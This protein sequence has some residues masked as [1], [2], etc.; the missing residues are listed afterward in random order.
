MRISTFILFLF[1]ALDSAAQITHP[2]A[3]PFSVMEQEVGLSKITIQYSRPAVKGRTVF[4]QLVPYSRIWRV[5][6]NASTKITLDSDIKVLGNTLS[7]G[8]YALYAFPNENTWE[9]V[10]HNTTTH[11]G[12][13]R[14]AYDPAEDALRVT[15]IPE[16]IPYSQENFLITFDNITHNSLDMI[17]IWENAKIVVPMTVDTHNAML[18]EIAKQLHQNPTA[19][20]YYE[21]ARY[22]QEQGMEYPLALEYLNKAI[23]LGGDTYYFHRV[24][25]LVEAAL[26]DYKAALV[27][28]QK[29]MVIAAKEGKDEFVRMNQENSI[30]W[31]K[32]N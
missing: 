7:K 4:G 26:G 19:Q 8:I 12:D 27:S 1:L 3:S 25:S 23:A 32:I 29:S 11:W 21:A 6:A 16:K 18:G 17:W 14:T 5:G 30:N 20:T 22:Y 13:G 9:I 15:V 31:K 10:F 28:A 2:K 24:K